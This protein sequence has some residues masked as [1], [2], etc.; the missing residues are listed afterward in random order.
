MLKVKQLHVLHS[1]FIFHRKY[2]LKIC[3]CLWMHLQTSFRHW[4]ICFLVYSKVW[5]FIL[6][7]T[8][9]EIS[10]PFGL[11]QSNRW[12]YRYGHSCWMAIEVVQNEPE[13]LALYVF[14][15][16]TITFFASYFW[17]IHSS[18]S[19][20]SEHWYENI[21]FSHST[22]N[23]SKYWCNLCHRRNHCIAYLI[24]HYAKIFGNFVWSPSFFIVLQCGH[25]NQPSWR[26]TFRHSSR[27]ISNFS[28]NK[29]KLPFFIKL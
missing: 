29:L 27:I 17:F 1:L 7:E 28:T 13:L 14:C 12:L 15:I 11:C 16:P 19:P 22:W 10:Y 25:R 6:D 24:R 8:Y 9:L 4:I 2:N 23:S 26:F 5:R 18:I 3:H 20:Q 21:H